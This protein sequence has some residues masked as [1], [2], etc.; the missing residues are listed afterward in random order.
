MDVLPRRDFLAMGTAAGF[1]RGASAPP[2]IAFILLDDLG[3]GDLGCYGQK[4]IATP[5]IDALARESL[6]FTDCYAGGAVCAPSR[7]VLMTGL[8]TGHT[9]VRANAGTVPL[10]DD[11]YTVGEML[12]KAGYATGCFGKWG[13]GDAGSSGVATRQG[14]DEFF[15]YLHQVHA[16]DYWTPF[17]RDGQKRFEL[18]GN[19]GGK[20]GQYSAD[21]IHARALDFLRKNRSRPHFL[22]AAYTLP[23]G[24]FEPPDDKPYSNRDWPQP[25]K[26]YAA[27]ITHADRQVGELLRAIDRD[28]TVVF[29]ASDNGGEG[30]KVDFF[31]SNGHLRGRKAGLYEGGIRVP[32]IVRWPGR[33]RPGAVS[34]Y[35][36][37][38]CDVMP[39]LAEV[40]GVKPPSGIDGVSVI[41]T[42]LGRSQPERRLYWEQYAFDQRRN[43]LRPESLQQA[44][45]IG[46]WKGVRP[47][48]NAPLELYNLADDPSEARDVSA[49]HRARA[50][51]MDSFLRECHKPPRPHNTG[52][53]QFVAT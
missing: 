16:H 11:D 46:T 28:N 39:T 19:A 23:H 33:V 47:K 2:N 21:L 12:K 44:G 27:M 17:L 50:E 14:F 6:R 10:R 31:R 51:E 15:G 41:P 13:L 7:S 36:W 52:D 5:N 35:A 26:N 43:E 37:S 18:T 48:P 9:P 38:F 29:L 20:H 53:M 25:Y 8:H 32:M 34:S 42:L 3:W 45:R 4:L 22:Y 30:E 49:E 24:R 40:A 1:A